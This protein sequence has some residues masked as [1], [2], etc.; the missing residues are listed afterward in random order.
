M[1]WL[2]VDFP[3]LAV[4]VFTRTQAE[5][6]PLVVV[7]ERLVYRYSEP[8]RHHGIREGLS[9]AT[10]RALC[11][12]LRAV[13]RDRQQERDDLQLLAIFPVGRLDHLGRLLH[14]PR[15]VVTER[16]IRH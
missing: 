2:C 1:L 10:A 7:D 15:A 9:L 3:Q 6:D 4:E 12:G 16:H 11:A 13:E 8:C 14:E 5:S